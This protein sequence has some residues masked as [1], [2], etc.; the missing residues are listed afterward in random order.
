MTRS[1]LFTR[2]V[3][4]SAALAS[5]G[6]L[7]ISAAPAH[8][9]IVLDGPIG[10]GSAANFG[11]LS[12][13]TVT[14]TGPSVI[15]GDV[16][17]SPGTAIV[18]FPPG[19][20]GG[21]QHSADPEAA[22]AQSDLTT[23]YNVAASLTPTATGQGE[24]ADLSLIPGVY[25]GGE[26]SLNGELT[27]AGSA[28]SV[29]VF[30]AA[31]TLTAGS[32]AR[33]TMTGGA[34]ACNVFWQVGSSATLDSN[35]QFVGTVM[36][37]TSITAVTGAS[38]TGRLLADTGAVTLDSNVITTPTGCAAGSTEVSTSPTITSAA[39]PAA[40]VD[41][42]YSFTV[43]AS[44]TPAAAYSVTAGTLPA[45]L[46]LNGSTGA[47]SGVPTTAGS[48][49]F[50]I[51]ASNGTSPDA[52]ADYTLITAAAS[53][54]APVVPVVPVVPAAPAAPVEPVIPAV[55]PDATD[56]LLLAETGAEPNTAFLAV[57]GLLLLTGVVV[58]MA[59]RHRS[60]AA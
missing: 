56:D 35:S 47:I 45:G 55:T 46:A 25:S 14:N 18:G 26:L 19:I 41:A 13:S 37:S 16:G 8:A 12:A 11:V 43:T 20:I 57:G 23:A 39:P 15:A 28:D 48:S 27:L 36:A 51:T 5:A 21:V 60:V 4:A 24:L 22:Q 6:L 1:P 40:T 49:A 58:L 32:G 33:I 42:D 38:I 29:W 59:R 52:T 9:A 2:L 3:T 7:L 34:S 53:V 50:T 17:V 31:S 10:L 44:G 54:V 30:Q